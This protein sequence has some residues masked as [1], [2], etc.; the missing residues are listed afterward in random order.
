MSV[1]KKTPGRRETAS[2]AKERARRFGVRL[3]GASREGVIIL[4]LASC[5][6]L[7][8]ALFSYV[9]ADPGWSQSGPEQ[10]VANWMG[11]IGAWLAD[12][13]YSLF[14]AS[15]LWWPGMLGFAAWRLMRRREVRVEWDATALAVRAAGLVLLLLATTSLGSLHFFN[16]A[17]D[18][19]YKAGG[20]LGEGLSEALQPLV[21][22]RGATLLALA[23]FLCGFPLF[24]GLS[25]LSVMDELGMRTQRMWAWL[26]RQFGGSRER[27]GGADSSAEL[28]ANSDAS[29]YAKDSGR[30]ESIDGASPWWRRWLGL[31]RAAGWQAEPVLA[32]GQRLEPQLNEDAENESVS[33]RSAASTP[34]RGNSASSREAEPL[35]AER[36]RGTDIPWD[37][38]EHTPSA[39]RPEAAY[40]VQEER[41]REAMTPQ[42][43]AA[44]STPSSTPTAGAEKQRVPE[45][46]PEPILPDDDEPSIP[47]SVARP[48]NAEPADSPRTRATA[49]ARPEKSDEPVAKA[50][51]SDREG[52]KERRCRHADARSPRRG[53]GCCSGQFGAA[54]IRT[55]AAL[56]QGCTPRAAGYRLDGME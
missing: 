38:P 22:L 30:S 5:V 52:E 21:G 34:S 50:S 11:S 14:G 31:G 17:S 29:A 16:P 6:F 9:P 3:Q 10:S 13:L 47:A 26:A 48:I 44:R 46:V 51:D 23:A 33:A 41:I 35:R 4:L 8:L 20:I 7:L 53:R 42:R 1:D 2:Q 43:D 25:W 55:Y 32:G 24:T 19:P 28:A 49:T 56:R 39:K 12:V 18:L 45:T 40:S 15:A 36:D 27:T 54:G 37:V